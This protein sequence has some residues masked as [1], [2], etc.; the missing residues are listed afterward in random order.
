MKCDAIVIGGGV[1]GLSTALCLLEAGLKRVQILERQVLASGGSGLGTGSVHTQRW[2]ATDSDLIV[3]SKR[4]ISQISERSGG[5]FQLFSVGRLTVVGRNDADAVVSYGRHLRE[6]GITTVELS[7]QEL[8]KRFPGMNVS[9]VGAGL[10]TPEDG[11]VYPPAMIWALAGAIR[12]AGGSIWEGCG[13]QRIVIEDGTVRGVELLNG[14]VLESNRV[15]VA[16]GVWSRR[17]LQSSGLDLALKHSVTHNTVVTVG[18]TDRWNEVPSLL[19][20]IQGVIAIPRNPGTIMAANTAGEYES[21]AD[22]AE[23]VLNA[24][25][26]ELRENSQAFR[27]ETA[28]QQRQVVA[29]LRHRYKDYDIR[30]IVGHWAGLLDGTPDNHPYIGAYP[31]IDGLWVGCGLTGYGV[32]RGPGVGETL[33]ALALGKAPH[34][35]VS[36][37]GLG[38][39]DAKKDFKID[40]SSDNPFEGFK[41]VAA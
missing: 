7:P 5:V 12:R 38:R 6:C 3:R 27:E 28:T 25:T 34:V 9:D 16:S 17:V 8:Q 11:V 33:A 40:L 29:Q 35:D 1:V 32:Q 39:F 2:F 24:T 19:D 21:S 15:I 10:F 14:D 18:R 31:D 22:T 20:G 26:V 4:M 30:G 13:S 23:R 41:S 37:Y 36:H